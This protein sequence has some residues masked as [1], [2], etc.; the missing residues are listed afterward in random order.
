[1]YLYFISDGKNIKIGIAKDVKKRIKGLQTGNPHKLKLY[2]TI[3]VSDLQA[4]KIENN[5]HCYLSQFRLSGEWFNGEC[6]NII[7]SLSDEEICNTIIEHTTNNNFTYLYEVCNVEYA[8]GILR[9]HKL[10]YSKDG[11]VKFADKRK[12]GKYGPTIEDI[13]A[14]LDNCDKYPIYTFDEHKTAGYV[15]EVIQNQIKYV[16]SKIK[17]HYSIINELSE[18]IDKL[19]HL[20]GELN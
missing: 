7:D 18:K 6:K 8:D 9:K 3:E 2:R 15:K 5:I 16:N 13:L 1:M 11:S 17:R 4:K 12:I 19:Q 14:N 10:L 20:N